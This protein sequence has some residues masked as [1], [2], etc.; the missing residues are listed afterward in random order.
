MPTSDSII[1]ERFKKLPA[2]IQEMVTSPDTQ[3]L[4]QDIGKRYGLHIDEMGAL[5]NELIIVLLG[6]EMP[7]ALPHNVMKA[8][9]LKEEE[10]MKIATELNEKLLEPLREEFRLLY[11]KDIVEEEDQIRMSDPT[12]LDSTDVG[13]V[14]NPLPDSVFTGGVVRRAQ[15]ELDEH[16]ENVSAGTTSASIDKAEGADGGESI[17]GKRLAGEGHLQ[18]EEREVSSLKAPGDKGDKEGPDDGTPRYTADP[19][20]EPVG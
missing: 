20:R 10:A 14:S 6:L 13:G 4:V 9:H 12:S 11:K 1:Q 18:G 5:E 2:P 7:Q 17:E 16:D 19:Y 15:P 8:T 3:R